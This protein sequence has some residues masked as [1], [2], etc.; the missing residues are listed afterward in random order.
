MIPD[1][2]IAAVRRLESSALLARRTIS[3][4]SA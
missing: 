3:S 1:G 2:R 4:A